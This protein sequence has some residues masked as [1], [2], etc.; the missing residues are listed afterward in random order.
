MEIFPPDGTKLSRQ[1]AERV[2]WIATQNIDGLHQGAGSKN[3]IELHGNLRHLICTHCGY[4]HY[5]ET[6][7]DLPALPLCPDCRNVLRPD[8]VLY[9]EML[10]AGA[11]ELFDTEQNCGFDLVFSVGTTSL[12]HYVTQPIVDAVRR[13]ITVIEINPDETP[14]SHLANFRFSQPAGQTMQ[15]LLAMI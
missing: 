15:A 13:G 5:W 14:I 7:A 6:F 1:S 8:A 2:V 4:R 11:L 10:P 9:E 3:V 12:F